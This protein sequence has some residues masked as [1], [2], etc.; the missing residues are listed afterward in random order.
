MLRQSKL[1][2]ILFLLV[3]AATAATAMS[4]E[5]V[6][7]LIL[8]GANNHD[9]QE[10]TPVLKK[11]FDE[12]PRFKVVDVIADPS[13]C[14]AK[15]F[16]GCDVVA[17]NWSAYPNMTGHQWGAAAEKAF[18]DFIRSGGGFVTFHAGAAT[19]QDWP[20]FQQLVGITWKI[21]HTAHNAY[22]TFKVT[23]DDS[24]HPLTR[25]MTD[26][27]TT[28][29]LWHNMV[30]M[31]GPPP[32]PLVTVF[33][34]R[35]FGGT[36][37][38]EPAV[39]PTQLGKGR[40]LNIVLG[41]DARA[42][43]NVGWRTLMLRGA[44][45]AATGQVTIPIPGNWPS[46]A[47]AAV[48]VGVD[49]DAILKAVADYRF[50][51]DRKALAM[52]EQ[53]VNY[54]M[55]IKGDAAVAARGQ[56][57]AKIAAA[58][59]PDA[60]PEVKNFLCQQ[61]GMLSATEQVPLLASLLTDEKVSQM[62]RYAL[63]QIPGPAAA[64]AL[65]DALGTTNGRIKVGIINSLGNIADT[66]ALG[67]LSKLLDDPDK[68]IASSAAA[69]L[70]KIGGPEAAKALGEALPKAS[71]D[72]RAKVSEACLMCA[73]KAL[74]E[75]SK[76]AA[77]SIYKRFYAPTEPVPVRMAALRGLVGCNPIAGI[78]L[79]VEAIASGDP[80]MQTAAVQLVRRW[81]VPSG[82]PSGSVVEFVA[83][84]LN[85]MQK[86]E[87]KRALIAQL[88]REPTLEAMNLAV[89]RMKD[90]VLVEEAAQAVVTIA[91]ALVQT[92]RDEVKTAL[93]EVLAA[94]KSPETI[95]QANNL[96]R[97]AAK[98][99]NLARGATASSPDG[100]EPD[101]GSGPDAAAI[102]GNPETYWDEQDGQKLYRFVLTFPKPTS[103]SAVNIKGHAYRSHSPKD[104]D[105][106]CDEKVVKT[107][108]N[109]EYDQQTN[110]IFITFP[111]TTCTTLELKI[112]GYYAGSPG[113]RE[114]EVY[115]V[116]VDDLSPVKRAAASGPPQFKWRQTDSS[117][118][119]LNADVVV[120][121]CNYD[122]KEP[123]PYCHPVALADG[124]TLTWLNPPDHPWHHALWF[125]WKDLNGLTYWEIGMK[126]A[127]STG[128]I[129][130]VDVKATGNPDF[131][132]RIELA[133][134]YHPVDKPPVL[135]EKRVLEISPPDASGGYHIDWNST[136][137]AGERDVRMKGG[138]AGGGYAGL[139]ARMAKD[140]RDWQLLDSEG[141]QDTASAAATAPNTHG[142]RARWMNCSLVDIASGRPAGLAILDHPDNLRFPSQWHCILQTTHHFG[143]FSP[144]PLWSEP[145]TLAAG[146]SL[147]LRY[148]IL[149][150]AGRADR[151]SIEEQWKVFV[152]AA[153][154]RDSS[155]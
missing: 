48:V 20:E 110:E 85:V 141:R 83:S 19:S 136:F 137:T 120:W 56:L 130:V 78:D 62:A 114:L 33:S 134:S 42:M 118:A 119:L 68:A 8:T 29:E 44:E 101:G 65:R 46:T 51:K 115:D 79:L 111:R 70:G 61:L 81:K 140:S 6:R 75:G 103:V 39:I 32:K 132:A 74:A 106:L 107:I 11:L 77:A 125:A 145:H 49:P 13:K 2:T 117:L 63:E 131:S 95:E 57:A 108:T 116:N 92:D 25:G 22:H 93:R 59:K 60:A 34:E 17:N 98:S 67:E 123:M 40:G 16:A 37:K 96:L 89:A 12:C 53:L 4:A 3:T 15:T 23:I 82:R 104:F 143:Y 147:P 64:R 121:Q 133:L 1:H 45:W 97:R 18:V 76:E 14:D 99:V 129:D 38:F 28:D 154:S 5:P 138:T 153:C 31:A 151:Q 90:P 35:S 21:D 71:G 26:F 102:D 30:P 144:A 7:V 113:I 24:S 88:G 112:T 43:Q 73:D 135:T 128:R 150:H 41:H 155:W 124:T 122:K 84:A 9:W 27:W 127:T 91:P 142:K 86:P 47:A 109:A 55:S 50:G 105:I 52:V 148:R 36:G 100:F 146:K 87:H 54:S 72:Y 139:S 152:G 149:V 80:R 126:G 69:A 66:K 58:I 10:T 94:S